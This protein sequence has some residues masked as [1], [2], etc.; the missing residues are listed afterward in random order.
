MIVTPVC[1]ARQYIYQDFHSFSLCESVWFMNKSSCLTFPSPLFQLRWGVR[2]QR[3]HRNWPQHQPT[4]EMIHFHLKNRSSSLSAASETSGCNY[5][6]A[7]SERN[8]C[9]YFLPNT[10]F[11]YHKA[12]WIQ[13]PLRQLPFLLQMRS[14]EVAFSVWKAIL[15]CFRLVLNLTLALTLILTSGVSPSHYESSVG[16]ECCCESCHDSLA[17]FRPETHFEIGGTEFWTNE[18]YYSHTIDWP[19]GQRIHPKTW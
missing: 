4:S 18:R 7:A 5:L 8:D 6:R 17:K 10:G 13:Q 1:F 11:P 9:F 12:W 14:W 3:Q 19:N 15:G 2:N 16:N